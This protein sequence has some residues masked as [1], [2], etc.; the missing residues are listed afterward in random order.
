M[1]KKNILKLI[2]TVETNIDTVQDKIQK[3]G[4]KTYDKNNLHHLLIR[5]AKLLVHLEN[6][7]SSLK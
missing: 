4:V 5:Y 6:Q 1:T 3:Q 2:E 7:L